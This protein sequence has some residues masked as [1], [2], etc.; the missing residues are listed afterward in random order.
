MRIFIRRIVDQKM[1]K[2][3]SL[4]PLLLFAVFYSC[5]KDSALQSGNVPAELK[6]PKGFP[7]PVI[8]SDNV[9][10]ANRIALG[11]MLFFDPVLSKD[12]TVS[13]ASC[14]KPANY[15]SDTLAFSYG[16]GGQLGARNAPTLYNI[17]YAPALFWDGGVP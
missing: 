11:K 17:A 12:S 7:Q 9:P 13:C 3:I 5:T 1:K 4:L 15:F 16:V 2:R 14:H 6:I 8:P 10:T